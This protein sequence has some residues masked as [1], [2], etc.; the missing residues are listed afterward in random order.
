[1]AYRRL[2]P[3]SV[4]RVPAALNAIY[5]LFD[6]AVCVLYDARNKSPLRVIQNIKWLLAVMERPGVHTEVAIKFSFR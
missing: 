4:V 1:M 6:S 5:A 2:T 3:Y